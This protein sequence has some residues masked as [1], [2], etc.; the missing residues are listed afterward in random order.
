MGALGRKHK[1]VPGGPSS[2]LYVLTMGS[3]PSFA[4]SWVL[5]FVLAPIWHKDTHFDSDSFTSITGGA[6]RVLTITLKEASL[7][8]KQ[9]VR[10]EGYRLSSCL[11]LENAYQDL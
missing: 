3:G 5:R 1:H 6:D 11:R 8:Y 2:S 7:I 9:L 4:A 10:A